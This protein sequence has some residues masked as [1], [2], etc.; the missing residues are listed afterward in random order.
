MVAMEHYTLFVQDGGRKRKNRMDKV[1]IKTAKELK[2]QKAKNLRYKHPI[3]QYMS[4]DY[5]RSQIWDMMDTISDVQWFA[6]DIESLT[7]AL[8]GDED[9][10]YQ[11]RM[12]F[13]DL[14]AELEQFQNDLDEAWIPD[15]FDDLFPATGVDCFGGWLG[16]DTEERDYFG[17][18]PY[19][20]GLAQ[21]EAEKRICRMT[22]QEL[23]EA[24]GACLKVYA[25]FTALRYRYDCLEASLKII[26]ER[27]LEG[28]KLV[29]AIEEQYEKAEEDSKHFKYDWGKEV[30]RLDQMIGNVPQEYWV[31]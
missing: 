29:K 28:L 22:K 2:Q 5:I 8:A 15:Y 12:A 21:K 26:Q 18:D 13:S 24:V 19:E 16:Y 20:Y 1:K 23:L 9:E 6:D 11:F 31:Q 17:L 30:R 3:M 4:L 7:N 10:A 27:N 25:S 14:A